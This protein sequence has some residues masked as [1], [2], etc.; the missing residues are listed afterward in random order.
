MYPSVK[1]IASML[2]LDTDTARKVRG[3]MDG[4]ID[5]YTAEGM[6]D[7]RRRSM[8]WNRNDAKMH[9][10]DRVLGTCGVEGW[11]DPTDYRHG[12]GYCNTGDTYAATICLITDD[13]GTRWYLGS[14][15]DL[16]ERNVCHASEA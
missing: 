14:W 12:V 7:L 8:Y 4:T 1:R 9:A 6:D 2:N 11:A 3:L 15:G 5:P 10:I 16:A 13:R